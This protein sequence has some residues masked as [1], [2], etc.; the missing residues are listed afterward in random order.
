[1]NSFEKY[2]YITTSGKQTYAKFYKQLTKVKNMHLD[3]C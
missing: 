1:M 3:I 2:A